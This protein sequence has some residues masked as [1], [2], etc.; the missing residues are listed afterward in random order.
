MCEQ[1]N[2]GYIGLGC[3]SDGTFSINYYQ[4]EYCLSTSTGVYD[5]L[6]NL[7]YKLKTYKSCRGLDSVNSA[8][9]LSSNLQYYAQS[10][11]S[12]DS[13]VCSDDSSMQSRRSSASSS[14]RRHSSAS[15]AHKSWTTKVKYAMGGVLLVA[16][17][18]MFTGILFTN[19]RRRKALMQRKFRQSR[20][21]DKSRRSRRS[22]SKSARS[23]SSTRSKSRPRESDEGGVFT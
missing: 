6:S 21:G 22:S 15:A 7:N 11:S 1:S 8:D 14:G 3:N 23:R 10:C 12:L 9:D 2:N 20:S 16:S 18:I 17:L 5:T 4:D 19:R 13:P